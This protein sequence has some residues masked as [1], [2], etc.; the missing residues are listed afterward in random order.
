MHLQPRSIAQEIARF[1]PVDGD[2]SRLDLMVQGLW[3][4]GNA[5]KSLPELLALFERF[6]ADEDGN[7][8]FWTILHG[9]ETFDDYERELACSLRRQPSEF[10]VLLAGRMLNSGAITLDGAPIAEVLTQVM[11]S[12][13][14]PASVADTA[15]RFLRRSQGH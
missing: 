13:H 12:P 2:W 8:V 10:A 1:S 7:G 11:D 15:G 14:C 4:I 6:P 9:I 5:G 3:S